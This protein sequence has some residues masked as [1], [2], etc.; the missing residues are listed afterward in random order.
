MQRRGIGAWGWESKKSCAI[1]LPFS[2]YQE[3]DL[4]F[5]PRQEVM[6]S[7]REALP[8]SEAG[9]NVGRTSVSQTKSR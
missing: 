2:L 6:E 3:R 7:S 5:S 4:N 8:F 9:G 1:F